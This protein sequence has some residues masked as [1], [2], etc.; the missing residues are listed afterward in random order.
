MLQRCLYI[1]S[2]KAAVLDRSVRV[3]Y[4]IK[5]QRSPRRRTN[6]QSLHVLMHLSIKAPVSSGFLICQ[7]E[8]RDG[9]SLPA[10]CWSW[11]G[12]QES[13]SW[14]GSGMSRCQRGVGSDGSTGTTEAGQHRQSGFSSWGARREALTSTAPRSAF[15]PEP[16]LLDPQVTRL[17]RLL[18]LVAV[19]LTQGS[20]DSRH[21]HR[22]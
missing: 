14:P 12:S 18:F 13:R 6:L 4:Q 5:P 8:V 15:L 10:M 9:S 20:C 2:W 22:I 16:R 3:P 17:R 1:S 19:S 21:R 7:L 11:S